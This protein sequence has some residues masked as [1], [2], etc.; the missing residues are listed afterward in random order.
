MYVSWNDATDYLKWLSEKTGQM[1]RLPTEAEWEYAA[2][3]GS[4]TAY[5]WGEEAS[6]EFANY[7]FIAKGKDRWE[8]TSPV[9]SFSSNAYG[10]YDTAGNVWE[11]TCSDYKSDYDGSE[12]RCLSNNNAKILRGGSWNDYPRRMRSAARF[13]AT[14]AFRVYD[15]G[16]RA[17]SPPVRP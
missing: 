13:G 1:F 14:P 12:S 6:H 4:T 10:L 11:W 7:G 9:G 16:F 3:A 15:V 8:Y 2:R 5:W 17:A